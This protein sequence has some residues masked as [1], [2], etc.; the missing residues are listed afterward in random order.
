M[1]HSQ[2]PGFQHSCVV[3]ALLQVFPKPYYLNL[4]ASFFSMGKRPSCYTHTHTHTSVVTT[5]ERGLL[6]SGQECGMCAEE[7]MLVH[8]GSWS[9]GRLFSSFTSCLTIGAAF[10]TL[11]S[12]RHVGLSPFVPKCVAAPLTCSPWCFQHTY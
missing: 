10:F 2:L 1:V 8:R 4:G 6:L 11:T 9:R 12:S 3:W 5:A 7:E